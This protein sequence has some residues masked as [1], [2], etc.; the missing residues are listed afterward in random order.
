M[1]HV[2]AI[3][4]HLDG[5]KLLLKGSV[6]TFKEVVKRPPQYINDYGEQIVAMAKKL[7]SI[8]SGETITDGNIT[9]IVS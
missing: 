6:K 2:Q 1:D 7:P 5:Y 3:M 4:A 8:E 9:L